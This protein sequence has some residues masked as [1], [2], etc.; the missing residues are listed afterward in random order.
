MCEGRTGGTAG[1]AG[2]A[3]GRDGRDGGGGAEIGLRFH[4]IAKAIS[5]LEC[6]RAVRPAG[7]EAGGKAR[8]KTVAGRAAGIVP[9]RPE[10]VLPASAQAA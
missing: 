1:R 2:R 5:Q 9:V 6:L 10:P 3:D 8:G 4:R 7:E